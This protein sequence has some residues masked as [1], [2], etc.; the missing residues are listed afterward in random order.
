MKKT[1][2][3]FIILGIIIAEIVL[4]FFSEIGFIIYAILIGTILILMESKSRKDRWDYFGEENNEKILILLMIIPI[5]RLASLF[6]DFNFFWNVLIFYILIIC[7]AIY[8]AIKL[9]I[10]SKPFI[11]NPLYFIAI[12]IIAGIASLAAK[13]LLKLE[14]S[15]IL[16]L[17]P[18]IAYAEEILFRG[19]FQNLLEDKFGGF[20]I[21]LT[22]L[23][24]AVFS[25]SYGYLFTAIAFFFSLAISTL[26]FFKKNLYFTFLLNLIFHALIFIFY[27][28]IFS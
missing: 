17:I 4:F 14:F 2:L 11:G 25:F 13:Y 21:I 22:C 26:Y 1:N 10:K 3:I 7:L 20:S 19:G 15:E 24:Y 8:Y 12:L 9:E 5:C 18:I 6:L 23:L 28:I 27:P 16:F